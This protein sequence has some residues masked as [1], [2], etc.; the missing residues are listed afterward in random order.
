MQPK[1]SPKAN[2]FSLKNGIIQ[3]QISDH[4]QVI[5]V[6]PLSYQINFDFAH[7]SLSLV[8]LRTFFGERA[9]VTQAEKVFCCR[10]AC[11]S[12]G[13]IYRLYAPPCPTNLNTSFP[14][15]HIFIYSHGF[16]LSHFW[17][18]HNAYHHCVPLPSRVLS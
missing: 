10:S 12:V 18:L 9:R 3:I 13:V 16:F 11:R 7:S 1:N 2:T 6:A 15:Q 5:I 8:F 17:C 14:H 4:L